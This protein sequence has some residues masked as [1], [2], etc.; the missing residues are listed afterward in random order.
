M[1]F[2]QGALQ[3]ESFATRP[4]LDERNPHALLTEILSLA[5]RRAGA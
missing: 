5:A 3:N 2:S 4:S 1:R